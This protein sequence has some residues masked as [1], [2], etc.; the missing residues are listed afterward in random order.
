MRVNATG[1]SSDDEVELYHSPSKAHGQK[2][3]G[4]LVSEAS[5]ST[6]RQ[7]RGQMPGTTSNQETSGRSGTI[8]VNRQPRRSLS[9]MPLPDV[10]RAASRF[11]TASAAPAAP[12]NPRPTRH[13]CASAATPNIFLHRS[14][15]IPITSPTSAHATDIPTTPRHLPARRAAAC[16][17]VH[18]RQPRAPVPERPPR[19]FP[20]RFTP[21]LPPRASPP[22]ATAGL[23]G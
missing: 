12:T 5:V 22:R 7:K 9:R 16:R 8:T 13:P 23:R 17:R 6:S 2:H 10:N 15:T 4:A 11:A 3:P 1:V 19:L 21:I 14:N 20:R 18:H